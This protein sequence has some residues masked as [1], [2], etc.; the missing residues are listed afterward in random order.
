MQAILERRR[1]DPDDLLE[2]ANEIELGQ[3]ES[4][5]TSAYPKELMSSGR[6]A[7]IVRFSGK[8]F[9]K[10][11]PQRLAPFDPQLLTIALEIKPEILAL[12]KDR[13]RLEPMNKAANIIGESIDI[14][15]FDLDSV[16]W[17]RSQIIYPH[18]FLPR[19][20]FSRVTAVLLYGKN[21]WAMFLKWIFPLLIVMAIVIVSPSIEGALGDIRLAIPPLGA[22]GAGGDAGHLQEYFS[23]RSLSHLSR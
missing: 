1:I 4:R 6:E 21:E 17:E 16:A 19:M 13:L 14:P 10:D 23:A 12:G 3:Y 2:L 5:K 9:L 7:R 22:A 18:E 8:F 11:V 20:S 15:G